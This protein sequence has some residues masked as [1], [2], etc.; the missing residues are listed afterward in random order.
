MSQSTPTPALGSPASSTPVEEAGP[1]T[2]RGRGKLAQAAIRAAGLVGTVVVVG[3]IFAIASGGLFLYPDNLLGLLRS[4]STLAI[5]GLGL[6]TVLMVGQIDLSFANLYGL[7]SMITAVGLIQWHWPLAVAIVIGLVAGVAVGMVNA[8]LVSY[9]KIPSFIAT[10]GTSTLVFGITLLIS[11]GNNFAPGSPPAS[12]HIDPGQTAF[13]TGISNL[14]LP[15]GFPM[16]AVWMILVAIVFWLLYSRSLFGFRLKAIGGNPI[17]A[18][19]ARLPVRRYTFIAFG[20]SGLTAA[21]AGLL[22][23]SFIGSVQ[24]DAGQSLLFPAFAAVVIGGASL[25]GGRGSVL[26]TLLGALLLAIISNALALL[27]VGA[28]AQQIVLGV[29]TIG[30]VILDQI[31][32]RAGSSR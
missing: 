21:V 16:Q 31:T 2:R 4:M 15:F 6:T 26:G 1:L 32:R 12:A 22:D 20:I 7:S 9:A 10:L 29:V 13:F 8:V 14:A 30:A 3:A 27:A 17:A 19:L 23:L 24:P 18:R 5:I 11:S 25:Q 28:F